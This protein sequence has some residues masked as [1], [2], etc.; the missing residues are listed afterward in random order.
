MSP[1]ERERALARIRTEIEVEFPDHDA[2]WR[3]A[4]AR[5]QLDY[6]AGRKAPRVKPAIK[7]FAKNVWDGLGTAFLVAIMFFCFTM[8]VLSELRG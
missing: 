4:L 6:E 3:D 7:K 1:I 5:E 8:L 2:V